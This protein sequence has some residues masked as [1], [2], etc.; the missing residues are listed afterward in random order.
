MRHW[1]AETQHPDKWERVACP[2]TAD[3][4][5]TLTPLVT[6]VS[7]GG[8]IRKMKRLRGNK[9]SEMP[10]TF[11]EGTAEGSKSKCEKQG[12]AEQLEQSVQCLS[13]G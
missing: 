10:T 1:K 6:E 5:R 7:S 8:T 13:W 3:H 4:S 11:H 2:G 12:R 9:C